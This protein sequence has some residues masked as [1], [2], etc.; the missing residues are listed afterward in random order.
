MLRENI[1]QPVPI[2]LIEISKIKIINPRTRNKLIHEQIKD[3]IKNRGL[4]KPITVRKISDNEFEYAL[5]CGQ[6]RVE[7]FI[8]LEE[9]MIPAIIRNI[10]EEEA[11]IMSL[12]ENIARRNP[13]S[14]EL[15][16]IIKNMKNQGMT[17]GEI[18][19]ITGY[20]SHWVNSISMLL[21]KGENSL[22]AAV[23][24]GTLPLY[25]AVEFARCDS[26]ETQNILAEAYEKKIIK[27][28][29]VI[30]LRH[31]LNQRLEGNKGNKTPGFVYNKTSKRPSPEELKE[32]FENSIAEHKSVF[33]HAEIV[34]NNLLV[35]HEIFNDIVKNPTFISLLEKENL[36]EIPAQIL[37]PVKKED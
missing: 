35:I 16:Q 14:N 2:Y 4:T 17:D 13:R 36:S 30:K 1:L 27:S 11:Y 5:I 28:R 18:A 10:S 3:S 8:R 33:K 29:D 34:K 32:L 25:L 20:T 7:A 15:L 21:D 19:E 6:G 12:V 22:L 26:I 9:K 37:S 31:I 24:K 23:E